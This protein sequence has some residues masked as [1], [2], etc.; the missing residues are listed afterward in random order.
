MQ[1]CQ[2]PWKL[3]LSVTP[4]R[5]R[6]PYPPEK[7]GMKSVQFLAVAELLSDPEYPSPLLFNA[8]IAIVPDWV[9]DVAMLGAVQTCGNTISVSRRW[10]ANEQ[11]RK[12]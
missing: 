3:S 10:K 7:N 6:F 11:R 5:A 9:W 8:Y 4:K 2:V 12:K 1:M